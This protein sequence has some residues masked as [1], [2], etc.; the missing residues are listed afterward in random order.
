MNVRQCWSSCLFGGGNKDLL[1]LCAHCLPM[2]LHACGDGGC[3]ACSGRE[4]SGLDSGREASAC[5]HY[6]VDYTVQ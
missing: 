4:N 6:C 5:L 3:N 2:N 1:C